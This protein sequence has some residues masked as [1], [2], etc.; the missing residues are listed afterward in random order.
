[1]MPLIV[2]VNVSQQTAPTPSTLQQTGALISQGG[3][4]LTPGTY[5]LLTSL[6]TLATYIQSAKALASLAWSNGVVT[7]TTSAAHGFATN[8]HI[9]MV[10]AGASPTGYNGTFTATVTGT[11]TFTYPLLS[12]PGSETT[13]GTYLPESTNELNQMATTFFAQGSIVPVYVLEL[14]AGDAAAG[15]PVLES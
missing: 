3:T 13:A 9:P 14:G 8:L 1:M 11:D 4:T 6:Q 2:Q 5:Q 7:A 10:I 15:V 12:N